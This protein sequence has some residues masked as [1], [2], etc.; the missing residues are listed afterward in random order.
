MSKL[1][2]Q[3]ASNCSDDETESMGLAMRNAAFT[4]RG[5]MTGHAFIEIKLCMQVAL[6]LKVGHEISDNSYKTRGSREAFLTWGRN[7]T[8]ARYIWGLRS[9]SA[10]M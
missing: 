8:K 7:K 3:A 4:L 5:V 2:R 9:D 10:P 6:L 1:T